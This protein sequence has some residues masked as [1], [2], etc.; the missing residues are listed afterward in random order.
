MRRTIVRLSSLQLTNIK[1]VKKGTIYT[2]SYTHLD[3]YKRQAPTIA[4]VITVNFCTVGWGRLAIRSTV[5]S[6]KDF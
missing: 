3:V 1:N 6:V 2:V 5:L 4:T